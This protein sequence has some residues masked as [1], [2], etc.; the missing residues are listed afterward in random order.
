MDH[1]L[2]PTARS[3]R[4]GLDSSELWGGHYFIFDRGSDNASLAIR[5]LLAGSARLN[6]QI[7]ASCPSQDGGIGLSQRKPQNRAKS[8]SVEHS[9]SPCSA[10]NA[11]KWASGTRL[12]CIPGSARNSPNSS[13]CR[14]VG[15]GIHAVS[16]ASQAC[17]CRHASPIDSGCSKMRGLVTSLRKATMLGHG[18]PTGP[19]PLS[20]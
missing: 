9:V 1:P 11:A 7:F 16:H 8:P 6:K 15:C 14:S 12:P 13:A 18:R 2:L 5:L 19:E 4:A 17:T 10:A 20:C 3:Q